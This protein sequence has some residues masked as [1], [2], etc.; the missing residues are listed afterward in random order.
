MSA[1]ELEIG[2]QHPAHCIWQG[3]EFLCKHRKEFIK[4]VF[5]DVLF[6]TEICVKGLS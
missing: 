1:P 5:Q 2:C 6:L 3:M 4:R